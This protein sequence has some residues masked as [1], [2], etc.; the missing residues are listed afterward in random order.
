MFEIGLPVR[1]VIHKGSFLLGSRCLIGKSVVEAYEIAN[2]LDLAVCVFSPAALEHLRA[3]VPPSDKMEVLLRGLTPEWEVPARHTSVLR[4]A[5]LNWINVR[6]EPNDDVSDTNAYVNKQFLALGKQIDE[7]V[8]AK[9]ANTVRLLNF[10]KSRR[11]P[12]RANLS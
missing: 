9:V 8:R 7:S 1:G 4:L 10:W 2:S 12:G 11:A 3:A 5:T 6:Y